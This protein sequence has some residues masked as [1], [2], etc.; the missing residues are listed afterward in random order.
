MEWIRRCG[1]G[2][3]GLVVRGVEMDGVKGVW[4]VGWR[5]SMEVEMD[6]V[7]GVKVWGVR[8]EGVR[9]EGVEVEGVEVEGVCE[10]MNG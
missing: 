6:G 4:L 5:C 3:G 7:K 1:S 8:A 2:I 10:S 9:V